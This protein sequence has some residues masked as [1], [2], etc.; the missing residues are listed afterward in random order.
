LVLPCHRRCELL[1][2]GFE[3]GP[4]HLELGVGEVDLQLEASTLGLLQ[5]RLPLY[6][7]FLR[8]VIGDLYPIGALIFLVLF[9][10]SR[11]DAS[12]FLLVL[13]LHLAILLS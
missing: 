11:R 6:F 3:L 12:L 8:R 9:C 13:S 1:R 5:N 7:S 2:V 4:V 10:L